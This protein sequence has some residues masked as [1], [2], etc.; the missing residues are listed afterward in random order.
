M[1]KV[2]AEFKA[3]PFI[4]YHEDQDSFTVG[5]EAR[6]FLQGLRVARLGVIA[7]AGKYRTGKSLFL[8]QLVGAE[9]NQGFG[10]GN[11]VNACTKGLWLY[12]RLLTCRDSHK[13]S[14]PALVIDTEGIGSLDA[15]STHDTKIFA[16]AMLLASFFVYNSVGSIDENSIQ[17]LSLVTPHAYLIFTRFKNDRKSLLQAN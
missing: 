11:S 15:N 5:D 16:L 7:I 4:L 9:P 3:I 14:F 12:T 6:E 10:V 17:N 2:N 8:N 1:S 13:Q